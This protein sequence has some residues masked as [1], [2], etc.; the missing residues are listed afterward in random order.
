MPGDVVGEP[1][2]DKIVIVDDHEEG[3]VPCCQHSRA[4]AT[5]LVDAE[6]ITENLDVVCGT[7]F[8]L[9][10]RR[11]IDTFDRKALWQGRQ[12]CAGI[13]HNDSLPAVTIL[14]RDRCYGLRKPRLEGV[15]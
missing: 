13:R 10:V 12:V 6:E 14:T 15:P 4:R 7:A 2:T 8:V 5:S 11:K 3:G 9:R 1:G